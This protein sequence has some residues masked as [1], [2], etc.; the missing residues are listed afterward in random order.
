MSAKVQVQICVG[1]ACHIMGAADLIVIE[2]LLDRSLRDRVEIVGVTCME[3]CK[4]EA[5]GKPP[6]VIIDGETLSEAT[7]DKVMARIERRARRLID[8]D[9]GNVG[10]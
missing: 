10:S 6:F 4:D 7:L 5:N 8:G 2:D 1:T 3:L 9:T